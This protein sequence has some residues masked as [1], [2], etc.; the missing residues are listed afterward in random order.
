MSGELKRDQPSTPPSSSPTS[1][2]DP[3]N[4]A[5]LTPLKLSR[6][7]LPSFAPLTPQSLIAP[8]TPSLSKNREQSFP[9]STP[10][11]KF[12]SNHTPKWRHEEHSPNESNEPNMQNSGQL[13]MLLGR[14]NVLA[15]V[16][17]P[18]FRYSFAYI[19]YIRAPRVDDQFKAPMTPTKPSG[20][21]TPQVSKI[22]RNP[23]RSDMS[24]Y[25]LSHD[26]HIR[27]SFTDPPPRRRA[28]QAQLR[29]EEY[30]EPD[31]NDVNDTPAPQNEVAY[32]EIFAGSPLPGQIYPHTTPACASCGGIERLSLLQPCQ[33]QICASCVTG[34]LNVVGEK[35][36]ICMYC[37]SPIQSFKIS[38]IPGR[39][40][41]ETARHLHSLPHSRESF[42]TQDTYNPS[43]VYTNQFPITPNQQTFLADSPRI[44]PTPGAPNAVLRMDN[45]PWDVTPP[46]IET[47]LGSPVVMSHVL[48]DRVDGRTLNHAY[49]ETTM[50]IARSTLRTHQNKVLGHGRRSRAVTITLSGQEELMRALFPSWRGRFE[51]TQP[52]YDTSLVDSRTPTSADLLT[53]SELG[54]ALHLI[55][56]PKSHFLKMPS[57]AYWSLLSILAKIPAPDVFAPGAVPDLLFDITTF[58]LEKYEAHF[59]SQGY[60]PVLHTKLIHGAIHCKA[61]TDRQLSLLLRFTNQP[62]PVMRHNPIPSPMA[63]LVSQGFQQP[64]FAFSPSVVQQSWPDVP[65]LDHGAFAT[66]DACERVAQDFG[67][68]SAL[69][70]LDVIDAPPTHIWINFKRYPRQDL[71]ALICIM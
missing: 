67:L 15:Y 6:A 64:Q 11:R 26:P 22:T 68:D 47:W 20:P 55:Q 44:P 28:P 25:T 5:L 21:F 62:P 14:L 56:S 9:S 24:N 36:M 30:P 3:R 33:H 60:D 58:A 7:R 51:G 57:L 10:S 29:N 66:M 54:I 32:A 52:V 42:S 37:L 18:N 63:P 8:Q 23:L 35:D 13:G 31:F 17:C 46:M 27:G 1:P 49:V 59:G 2:T 50:D 34:S 16:L 65:V 4:A 61:F 38:R 19:A 70:L 43:S 48:L 69:D 41:S 53:S 40:H 12:R 39:I 71:Y 45:V